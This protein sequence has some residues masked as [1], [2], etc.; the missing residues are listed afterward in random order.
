M[1][2][3][4][5]NDLAGAT[6]RSFVQAGGAVFAS[7]GAAGQ[8][9]KGGS[10]ESLAV[11]GGPKAVTVPSARLTSMTRWPRYGAAEKK[12]LHDLIDNNLFY[13]ELPK[14]EKEWQQFT[15][16]PFVKAHMNGSSALTSMYFALDLPPGSDTKAMVAMHSWRLPCEMAAGPKSRLL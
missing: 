3:T 11:S 4:K 6:R 16:A 12:A 7:M 9:L 8:A 14:F 5:V 15:K 2:D 10:L 1:S 13:Q